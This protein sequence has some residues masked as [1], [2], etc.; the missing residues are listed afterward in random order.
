M[1]LLSRPLFWAPRFVVDRS[2]MT[3]GNSTGQSGCHEVN[4]RLAA[5]TRTI[6]SISGFSTAP[7]T[8]APTRRPVA[9]GPQAPYRSSQYGNVKNGQTNIEKRMTDQRAT[10]LATAASGRTSREENSATPMKTSSAPPSMKIR[11]WAVPRPFTNSPTMMPAK[12]RAI[13]K[14]APTQR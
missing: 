1:R 3:P 7:R 13:S 6:S 12:P 5:I 2:V 11:T 14:V 10:G 9:P 4:R 8:N